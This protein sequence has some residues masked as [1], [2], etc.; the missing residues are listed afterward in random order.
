MR[1]CIQLFPQSGNRYT[2]LIKEAFERRSKAA[3][4]KK[5]LA[6]WWQEMV[7][8]AEEFGAGALPDHETIQS[9]T[10][11]LQQRVAAAESS[12]QQWLSRNGYGYSRRGRR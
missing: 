11:R 8:A 3:E 1:G 5:K 6:S 2:R 9:A 12:R 7:D 10:L 4:E